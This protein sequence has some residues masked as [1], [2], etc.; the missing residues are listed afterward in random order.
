ML[1]DM[2]TPPTLPLRGCYVISLRPTGQHDGMRRAAA[3]QGA[4][5]IGLSSL[6]IVPHDDDQTLAALRQ[7][8]QARHIV[9]TSPNAVHAAAALVALRALPQQHWYAVGE[10]TAKTLRRAGI[11]QVHT[12][13]RMD[14]EGLLG[15]PS[16]QALHGQPLTLLTA[17]G[18]RGLLQP[19]L[20]ARGAQV[21]RVHVYQR[22]PCAPAAGAVA[23]LLASGTAPL[24]LALSSGEAL[25]EL[26]PRLPDAAGQRL[27]QAKV[28]AA[29]ARLLAHAHAAGFSQGVQAAGP[30]P[31]QLLAAMVQAH[32]AAD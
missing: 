13:T 7:G 21:Q 28:A 32:S 23:R 18:G 27:R 14:S 3:A 31:Q 4:R 12:P 5:V 9:V 8:L 2:N 20:Q 30:R 1:L 16:L 10:G 22:Q 17:P 26:L 25:D 24:W 11:A 15:L 6:R 19:A 29:S